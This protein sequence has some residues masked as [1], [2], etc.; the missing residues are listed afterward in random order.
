MPLSETRIIIGHKLSPHELEELYARYT[1]PPKTPENIFHE[2]AWYTTR[3]P[4]GAYIHIDHNTHEAFLQFY[5]DIEE[6]EP[7]QNMIIWPIR[8]H[9]RHRFRS[10]GKISY[11]LPVG[12]RS[13]T[14]HGE[15][16][17]Y[18]RHN[19]YT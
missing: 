16:R 2:A 7:A 15:W 8:M 10:R 18:V 1:P 4:E 9:E 5:P 13:F 6:G 12:M 11:L 19:T 3:L 17:I 14:E